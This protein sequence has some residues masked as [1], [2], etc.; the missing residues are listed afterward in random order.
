[1]NK[2][3]KGITLG[4]LAGIL[5]VTPMIIMKLPIEAN[6]SAFSMWVI[7]GFFISASTLQIN[8]VLKG[9]LYSFLTLIP[10]A[11]LIGYEDIMALAP[12]SGMTCLLGAL[13]GYFINKAK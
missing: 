1:M 2:Y 5:D 6:L 3:F 11:I 9:I 12:I 8:A 13:L 4:A 7:I 10:S